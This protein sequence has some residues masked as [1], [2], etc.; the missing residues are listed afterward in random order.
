MRSNSTLKKILLLT[1]TSVLALHLQITSAHDE[2][3][4][5]QAQEA[6]PRR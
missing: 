6:I 2:A 5:F 3:R 4:P 1:V